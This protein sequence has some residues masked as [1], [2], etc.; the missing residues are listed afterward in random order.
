MK[1]MTLLGLIVVALLLSGTFLLCRD[2][3]RAKPIHPPQPANAWQ[4]GIT[5]DRRTDYAT[6]AE[7]T[8]LR[9]KLLREE[10]RQRPEEGRN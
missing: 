7:Q 8:R 6:E 5:P 2:L 10:R 9:E 1:P 3:R 4:K